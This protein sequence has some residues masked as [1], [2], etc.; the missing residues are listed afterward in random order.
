MKKFIVIA[1]VVLLS[2]CSAKLLL[3]TQSD[4]ERG[5]AMFKGLTIDEL[6]KGKDVFDKKC[7]QCHGHKR[8]TSWTEIQWRRIIPVMAEKAYKSKK[9]QISPTEQEQVL[10]YVVTMG[11]HSKKN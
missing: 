3:P 9:V 8:P 6:N 7:T 4:A 10:R 5:S 11:Q 1:A 2:S